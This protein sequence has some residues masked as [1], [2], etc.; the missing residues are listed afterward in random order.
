MVNAFEGNRAET[1]TMLPVL[2]AFMAAHQLPEV[3]VVADAGMLSDTNLKA[4]AAAGL[5]Y[6]VGQ[7]IPEVPYQVAQWQ[8][9]HPDQSPESG[10]V[11]QARPRALH[12]QGIAG[13]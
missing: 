11:L 2:E 13:R 5:R 6:I 12:H 1:R 4:L 3:T 8:R 9:Q 7:R 10:L